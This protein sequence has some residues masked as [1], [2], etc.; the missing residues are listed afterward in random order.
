M[1]TIEDA[2]V[3]IEAYDVGRPDR[4]KEAGEGLVSAILT[5][6]SGDGTRS[7]SIF[8]TEG[9]TSGGRASDDGGRVLLERGARVY[10][11]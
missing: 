1:R 2:D 5:A 11:A 3:I 9:N 7:V 8:W 10:A 4:S 6:T